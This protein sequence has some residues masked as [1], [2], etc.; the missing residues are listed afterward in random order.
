MATLNDA[1]QYSD[2]FGGFG[3]Q[4]AFL[5]S[6]ATICTGLFIFLRNNPNY[7]H[8]YK[9]HNYI[10][11]N[12]TGTDI[13]GLSGISLV[14][15]IIKCDHSIILNHI[16]LDQ[17]VYCEYIYAINEILTFSLLI[18]I[19][20][21]P[22][23][24]WS[25]DGLNGLDM[26]SISTI[27]ENGSNLFYIHAI[28]CI[29]ISVLAMYKF[30][31]MLSRFVIIRLEFVKSHLYDLNQRTVLIMNIPKELRTDESLL[32]YV[33]SLNI[34]SVESC[35]M[36]RNMHLLQ[37]LIHK[38]KYYLSQLEIAHIRIFK[39]VTDAIK[40]GN[41]EASLTRVV[42]KSKLKINKMLRNSTM[43][44]EFELSNPII[45]DTIMSSEWLSD[46]TAKYRDN[47]LEWQDI[48]ALNRNIIDQFHPIH[49]IHNST[50]NHDIYL[51]DH[52]LLKL[53]RIDTLIDQYRH[54]NNLSE[55]KCTD[56]AFVTFSNCT[57]Q[58]IM[59]QCMLDTEILVQEAPQ[60]NDIKWHNLIVRQYNRSIRSL[61]ITS[62]VVLITV[63]WV[64]FMTAV[65]SLTNYRRIVQ[66][67]PILQGVP[68]G[69]NKYIE[70]ILPTIV[71]T[72]CLAILPYLL[73]GLSWIE[74][75]PSNSQL[76]LF[77][78]IRY[79]IFSVFNL[80]FV[81]TIGSSLL[82]TIIDVIIPRSQNSTNTSVSSILQL[83]GG[84]IPQG[85]FFYINYIVLQLNLHFLELV[86][87]NW[88]LVIKWITSIKW[89]SSTPRKQ[90]HYKKPWQFLYFYFYPTHAL[91]FM[92]VLVYSILHPMIII[93]GFIYYVIGYV[94]FK[95]QFMFAYV[96]KYDSQ[97]KAFPNLYHWA[98]CGLV[99][100]QLIVISILLIKEAI[101]PSIIVLVLLLLTIYFWRFSRHLIKKCSHV[102]L[103]VLP[104]IMNTE[105]TVNTMQ[106]IFDSLPVMNHDYIHENSPVM[107]DVASQLYTLENKESRETLY[108][109]N[110]K[111]TYIH[112]LFYKDMEQTMM[113]PVKNGYI[114]VDKYL[115]SYDMLTKQ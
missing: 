109:S 45:T 50:G 58:Q 8:L 6:V 102:P 18:P 95:H 20:L 36:V 69:Y 48:Y 63:L 19:I 60:I 11:K 65:I 80:I 7:S 113:L 79:F 21:M 87:F 99:F 83:L 68:E 24:F 55:F 67:F 32:N 47:T 84:N 112:P 62:I 13:D 46:L 91:I 103:D 31:M 101:G 54:F 39:N 22:L 33:Q 40:H 53:Q 107:S 75:L 51:V 94:I 82:N 4:C 72:I 56:S 86:Q 9:N 1:K 17:Y 10:W 26:F 92:I 115:M 2:D 15:F 97:G 81:F 5:G 73:V 110:N 43:E 90:Q 70:E 49:T 61:I 38:R 71:V 34:G 59:V 23:H 30:Y 57:S 25:N 16:G 108:D 100:L 29:Y 12:W 14:S 74:K 52:L 42:H 77:V 66:F 27:S 106:T 105:D 44:D 76:D 64:F 111:T 93:L 28:L 35:L 41:L 78:T 114:R 98:I 104:P 85:G 96:P 3:I 37:Q 88:A 89:I